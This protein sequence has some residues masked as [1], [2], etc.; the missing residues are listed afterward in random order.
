MHSTLM[1]T[2]KKLPMKPLNLFVRRSRRT[3]TWIPTIFSMERNGFSQI[4]EITMS[5]IVW[6]IF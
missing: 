3:V 6:G 5:C 4:S 1:R 2:W